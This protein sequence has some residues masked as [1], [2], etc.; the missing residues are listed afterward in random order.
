M[1]CGYGCR[2]GRDGDVTGANDGH[3]VCPDH[4]RGAGAARI[5]ARIDARRYEMESESGGHQHG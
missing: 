4:F 5:D 2:F 3:S 1:N